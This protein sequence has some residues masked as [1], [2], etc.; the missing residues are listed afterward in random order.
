M[1]PIFSLSGF[2]LLPLRSIPGVPYRTVGDEGI[3]DEIMKH[4]FVR[5]DEMLN[6]AVLDVKR[7]SEMMDKEIF[8]IRDCLPD[9]NMYM[10]K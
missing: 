1:D 6:A 9:L 10:S 5:V 3:G 2:Q 8:M 7:T 4:A